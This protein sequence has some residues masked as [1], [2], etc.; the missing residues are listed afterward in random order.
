MQN[1]PVV[2]ILEIVGSA[3][4]KDIDWNNQDRFPPVH[5]LAG[6]FYAQRYVCALVILAAWLKLFEYLSV[7]KCKQTMQTSLL[8]R[9]S[10]TIV[11]ISSG[12]T[13]CWLYS[14]QR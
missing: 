6:V 5:H 4:S 3:E 1:L 10:L 8:L 11:L 13:N 9:V 2:Y 7:F 14:T 12:C